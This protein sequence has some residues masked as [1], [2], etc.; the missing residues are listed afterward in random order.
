MAIA[1]PDPALFRVEVPLE[2]RWG[3]MDSLGH[4]NNAAYFSY[5]E[6]ARY[7]YAV[8]LGRGQELVKPG[9]GIILASTRCDFVKEVVFPTTL[10]IGCRTIR[11]GTTSYEMEYLVRNK[12]DGACHSLGGEVLV[13][14]DLEA[15]TKVPIPPLLR[16]RIQELEGI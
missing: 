8:K 3:D 1:L 14:Y 5:F 6:C 13:V 7:G 15:H 9:I 11:L 4:V 16:Q 2:V 12:A 10:V